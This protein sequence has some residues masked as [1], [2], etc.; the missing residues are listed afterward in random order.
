MNVK[1]EKIE[2]ILLSVVVNNVSEFNFM[3]GEAEANKVV[4]D[5]KVT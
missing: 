5:N 3:F 2:K 4:A 1:A